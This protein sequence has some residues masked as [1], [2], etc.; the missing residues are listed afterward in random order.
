MEVSFSM[1]VYFE[2]TDI[3]YYSLTSLAP[4]TPKK[5]HRKTYEIDNHYLK[6]A[7]QHI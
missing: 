3:F 7:L 4:I 5:H 2:S 6:W 1:F